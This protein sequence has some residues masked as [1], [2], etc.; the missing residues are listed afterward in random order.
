MNKRLEKHDESLIRLIAM[1][2][3]MNKLFEI[4]LKKNLPFVEKA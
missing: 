2:K 4:K 1:G 3:R